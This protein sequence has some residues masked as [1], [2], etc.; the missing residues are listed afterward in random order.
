MT[1][2]T[3]P[4]TEPGVYDI[5]EARYH[6]HHGEITPEPSLSCGD[7][8]KLAGP[9]ATCPARVLYD[10]QNPDTETTPAKLFGTLVHELLLQGGPKTIAVMP[11]DL[12]AMNGNKKE[13]KS[14]LAERHEEGF[15]TVKHEV[16]LKAKAMVDALHEN[17]IAA[18]AYANG[19]PEQSLI[20]RDPSFG[21]WCRARLDWMPNPGGMFYVDYKTQAAVDTDSI[22]RA[23]FNYGYFQQAAWYTDGIKELG[24]C[25]RPAFLFCFQEKEPP[26]LCRIIQPAPNDVEWGRVVNSKAKRIFADCLQQDRWPGYADDIDEITMPAWAER[27]LEQQH[28]AGAFDAWNEYQ[29]P[30]AAE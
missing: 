10:R 3:Y 11:E 20:W 13:V 24:L 6:L 15:E 23:M 19:Q 21:I 22:S 29:T 30:A 7:T 16:F 1:E 26:F 27:Q 2:P 12:S 18:A 9:G 28:E 4:I 8:K 17:Q 14:W 5:P 25:E